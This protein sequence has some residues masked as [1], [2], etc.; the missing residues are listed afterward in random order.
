VRQKRKRGFLLASLLCLSPLL[1]GSTGQTTN[2][3]QRLL[4]AHNLERT[5]AGLH[6]LSWDPQLAMEAADW[7]GHLAELGD[8][9]HSSDDP[10][11][12]DPEGENLWLGTRGYFTPEQMVG[13]WIE[14]KRDF[15]PGVFPANSRTG[16]WGDVGHYT[17]LMWHSTGRVGCAVAPGQT[18]DVLVCRYREAGNVIG[19]QPF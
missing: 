17:Q 5:D 11:D 1:I 4:A 10:D 9:E 16:D 19:E 18:Y 7:A 3:A 14:E 2:L 13:S 15:V 6:P 8:L 12:P